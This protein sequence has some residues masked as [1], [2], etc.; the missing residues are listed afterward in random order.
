VAQTVYSTQFA[1][2]AVTDTGAHSLYTVPDGYR[3][4]L[5]S[6]DLVYSST[7]AA[8]AILRLAGTALLIITVPAGGPPI[9]LPW[10]GHQVLDEGEVLDLDT[11]GLTDG[12]VTVIASG[13]EL[14]LP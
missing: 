13:Y 11:S 3:A 1:C 9:N 10:R 7:A 8:L 6:V 5:R 4:V 14:T 12:Y 2:Q